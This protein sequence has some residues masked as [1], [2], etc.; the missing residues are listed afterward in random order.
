M[1]ATATMTNTYYQQAQIQKGLESISTSVTTESLT[2]TT[3]LGPRRE[4]LLR[5]VH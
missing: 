4:G 1:A 3:F 5:S 2:A